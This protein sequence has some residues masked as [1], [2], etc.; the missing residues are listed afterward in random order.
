MPELMVAVRAI[1]IAATLLVLGTAAFR[2]LVLAPNVPQPAPDDVRTFDG[3][4]LRLTLIGLSV[5]V[6][7]GGAWLALFA[8]EVATEGS[9]SRELIWTILGETRFGRIALVRLIAAA[10]LAGSLAI[11]KTRPWMS[12]L[13]ALLFAVMLGA[14]GHAGAAPDL[15]GSVDLTSDMVH[16]A[17]A[18]VWIG[19]L[20]SF[21]LLLRRGR[22]QPDT[23]WQAFVGR[24][25]QRFSTL[26]VASVCAL[27]L[28]GVINGLALV[29][30]TDA[31]RSTGYGQTLLLKV[32]LFLGMLILAA[33][34][35]VSLTP[36][37]PERGAMRRLQWNAT[38]EIAL[39]LGIIGLVGLLGALPPPGH[40]HVHT[41]DVDPG[42]SFVHLHSSDGMVD[43]NVMP[44][45]PGDVDVTIR[46]MNDDFTPLAA[47]SVTFTLSNAAAGAQPQSHTA[48]LIAAGSWRIE[49]LTIPAAGRWEVAVEIDLDGRR[50]L[51]L[52]GPLLIEP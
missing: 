13:L 23:H 3:S 8:G 42:S 18:S 39:A 14:I 48:K 10:V 25:T 38:A 30:T 24:C 28:T 52:D 6:A 21:V 17:A 9:S 26:A 46:L 7:S 5:A 40:A 37:L 50:K 33:V 51:S 47:L 1:H 11:A 45:H 22:Q 29:E 2:A 36:R 15:R 34:N 4:L 31:L 49:G 43:V 19:G 35:R 44:G 20:L 41:M 32:A 12:A 27:A 16:I